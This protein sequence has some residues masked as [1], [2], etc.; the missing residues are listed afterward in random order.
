MC[1][2]LQSFRLSPVS[3]KWETMPHARFPCG[4]RHRGAAAEF[5]G[6]SG[7]RSDLFVIN[8][9]SLLWKCSIQLRSIKGLRAVHGAVANHGRRVC[10]NCQCLFV[11]PQ[12]HPHRAFGRVENYVGGGSTSNYAVWRDARKKQRAPL[13]VNVMPQKRRALDMPYMI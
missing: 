11:S 9:C 6:V 13:T 10:L 4:S 2:P 1:R 5:V 7:R 8:D 3:S 12:L